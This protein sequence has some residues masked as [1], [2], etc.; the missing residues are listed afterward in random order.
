MSNPALTLATSIASASPRDG[1]PVEV[2]ADAL[3]EANR[4]YLALSQR[5]SE[6]GKLYNAIVHEREDWQRRSDKF[7]ADMRRTPALQVFC[8]NPDCT[9]PPISIDV[10]PPEDAIPIWIRGRGWWTDGERHLCQGHGGK[11]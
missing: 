2:L 4:D 1:S 9:T 10:L 11:P 3:L 6:L 8:D 5:Y 7:V